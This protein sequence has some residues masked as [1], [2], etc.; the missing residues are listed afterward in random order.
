MS[1]ASSK[2]VVLVAIGANFSIAIT[3]FVAAFLSG[4]SA[5]LSE[6]IHSLVDTGNQTLLLLGITFSKRPSDETHPF[7]YG[8]ERYFFTLIVAVLLFGMGG[9]MAIY[10][11]I[12]HLIRPTPLE[13]P[14]YAYGVL[15]FAAIFE[16]YTWVIALKEVRSRSNGRTV[17]KMIRDTKDLSVVTVLL[18][19]TAALSGVLVAFLGIFFGHLLNNPYLDGLASLVIGI[20]LCFVA[21]ILI[22]ESRNL[23]LGE[24]ADPDVVKGIRALAEKDPAV[25][26]ANYPLTMHFGPDDVLL[27]LEIQFHNS[28]SA[29]ELVAAVS[30]LEKAISEQHPNVNRIFIEAAP[31]RQKDLDLQPR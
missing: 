25:A 19:D 15:L 28:L 5:M 3:K 20:M 27:N 6:A 29:E 13:N 24:S 30:R 2:K 12:T 8:K 23:L 26:G 7:G 21:S 17:W 10:Q 1:S 9:G 11:G 22:L 16:G 4:S 18:E 14:I 31:F